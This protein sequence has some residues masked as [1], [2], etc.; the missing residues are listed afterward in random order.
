MGL[1][2]ISCHS[3]I[4][5]AVKKKLRQLILKKFCTPCY[6][7]KKYRETKIDCKYKQR[8]LDDKIQKQK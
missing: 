6:I 8:P 5:V 4:W 1:K 7:V 3:K 2:E